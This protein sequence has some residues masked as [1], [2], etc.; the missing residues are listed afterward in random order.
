MN[1]ANEIMH[2]LNEFNISNK[3][4]ALTTDNESAMLICEREIGSALDSEFSS[5]IFSH[6]RYAAHVLNLGV[7]QGLKLVDNAVI[8]A[9]KLA[10]TIKKSIR[11]CNSLKLFCELK[12]IKYLKPILDVEIRWN[13]TYYMLK[14]FKELEPALTLLAA[15]N[16]L[17]NSLYLNNEDWIAIKVNE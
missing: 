14:H 3:V 15:D 11:I 2:V 12:K 7:K 1:I 4:I 13:S 16:E 6:Y 5:M 17:I 10:K 8:K 9:R